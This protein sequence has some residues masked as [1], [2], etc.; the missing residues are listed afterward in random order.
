[1][2]QIKVLLV[3]DN[4]EF[5]EALKEYFSSSMGFPVV[6][7]AESGASAIRKVQELQ[8]DL[9]FVDISMPGMNGL[10]AT[11]H[12]KR[13][14]NPPQVVMLTGFDDAEYRRASADAGADG[15]ICK[16]DFAREVPIALE[17]LLVG[18]I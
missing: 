16:T 3:D 17:K 13:L 15:F 5:L 7:W 1:L 10:E 2:D 8:P 9:V 12:I 4:R 11:R 6:S 18:R 14:S